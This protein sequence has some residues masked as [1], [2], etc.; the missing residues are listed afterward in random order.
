MADSNSYGILS[1]VPSSTL[2]ILRSHLMV[3]ILATLLI[4]SIP[5]GLIC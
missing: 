2:L 1:S 5:Y 4:T 3:L